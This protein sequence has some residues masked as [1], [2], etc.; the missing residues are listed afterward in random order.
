MLSTYRV[1]WCESTA[2]FMYNFDCYKKNNQ[3]RNESIKIITKHYWG[4]WIYYSY[5]NLSE[6]N[7]IDIANVNIL[8][9]TE[10]Y[11]GT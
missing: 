2:I 1:I 11:R 5:T 3:G 6:H 8:F 7:M 9:P 10:A 4:N